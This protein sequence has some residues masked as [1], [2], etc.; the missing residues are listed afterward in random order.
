MV[1]RAIEITI[2]TDEVTAFTYIEEK[3]RNYS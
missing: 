3:E 1:K 2:E